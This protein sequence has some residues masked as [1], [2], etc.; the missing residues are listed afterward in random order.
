M[1]FRGTDPEAAIERVA[2]WRARVDKMAA[3]TRAMS[4]RLEELRCTLGDPNRVVELTVDSGGMLLD[5]RFSERIRRIPPEEA[6][7]IVMETLGE[8]RRRV[9]E[10]TAR[11]IG[12]TMGEDSRAGQAIADRIRDRLV[13]AGPEGRR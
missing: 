12:E 13:P 3:D 9:S 8:A 4:E 11:V 1:D 10:E 5:L 7:R 2:A 6:S